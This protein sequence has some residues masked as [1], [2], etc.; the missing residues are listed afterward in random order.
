MLKWMLTV[1]YTALIFISLFF[2]FPVLF[3][4]SLGVLWGNSSC[5]PSCGRLTQYT[6]KKTVQKHET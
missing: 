5:P 4:M 1:L 2:S 3:Y 6:N